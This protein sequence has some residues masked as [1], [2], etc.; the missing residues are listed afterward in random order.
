MSEGGGLILCPAEMKEIAE[1]KMPIEAIECER[2][3]KEHQRKPQGTPKEHRRIVGHTENCFSCFLWGILRSRRKK[4]NSRK[5][6][7]TPGGVT[8]WGFT[9]NV[10]YL[11]RLIS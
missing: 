2:R 10:R 4:G 1:I 8:E 11:E 7:S 3:P 5:L 6:G 9:E